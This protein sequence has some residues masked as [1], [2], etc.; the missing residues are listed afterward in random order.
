MPNSISLLK[1][2]AASTPQKWD[3]GPIGGLYVIDIVEMQG[4]FARLGL[5]SLFS[6]RQMTR[7][8]GACS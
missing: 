8:D 3:F 2:N 1:S 4:R 6:R 7:V 5:L